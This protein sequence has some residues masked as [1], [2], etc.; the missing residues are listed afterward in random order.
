MRGGPGREIRWCGGS[1]D[2][3]FSF[4]RRGELES[5]ADA[6][7]GARKAGSHSGERVCEGKYL[8]TVDMSEE[9]WKVQLLSLCVG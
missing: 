8:K 4:F 3:C 6:L 1:G 5:L 7:I 2:V 9:F